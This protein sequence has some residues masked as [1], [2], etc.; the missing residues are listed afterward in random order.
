MDTQAELRRHIVANN[1]DGVKKLLIQGVDPNMF[2]REGKTALH[3]SVISPGRVDITKLLIEHGADVDLAGT[4]YTHSLG[5][6]VWTPLQW[7]IY[8]LYYPCVDLLLK[9]GADLSKVN[10]DG[11]TAIGY[12]KSK[13]YDKIIELIEQNEMPVKGVHN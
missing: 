8:R 7:A 5:P 12:V 6:C 4:F 9:A 3:L 2:D 11:M 13:G 10:F 1:Y